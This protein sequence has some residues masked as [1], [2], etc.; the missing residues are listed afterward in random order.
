[1]LMFP[2]FDPV[3]FSIG[4]LAVRWYALAYLAGFVLG[5]R[6]A[7]KL[8]DRAPATA[9]QPRRVDYD[10]FISWGVLGVV[11]GGRLG[12][13]IFYNGPFYL[14][15]PV[16]ALHVW[17]GG[18]SFHGGLLGMVVAIVAFTRRRKINTLAFGD[19][20]ATAAP[21]GLGLGR[22]ANFING[23]LVGR[24][25][26]NPDSV[27]WAM[28]FPRVDM[29]PRH[30]SQLYEAGLEGLVLFIV[31]ITLMMRTDV[32][33][34]PGLAFGIFTCLYACFRAFA[35]LF[36]TPDAQLGFLTEGM[37]MGQIL[38]I[39]MFI[40]GAYLIVRALKKPAQPLVAAA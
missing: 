19:V 3:A 4:P 37:T 25:V 5:W 27:P 14:A 18:M 8:A 12:Y 34:R 13:V 6:L 2:E 24:P 20:A 16:E 10:D 23:E 35:E 17:Q 28:V 21:I 7:L 26:T 15:H 31:M 40:V 9:G 29:L 30:P 32:R 39:P 11:L 22:I 38:C 36:R 33:R 1:M